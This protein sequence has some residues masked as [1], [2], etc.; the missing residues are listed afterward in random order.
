MSAINSSTLFHFT[1]KNANFKRIVQKGLRFSYSFETFSKEL[2]LNELLPASITFPKDIKIGD[3]SKEY[4]VAIPMVCFC[5]IPLLRVNE[6]KQK[7]GNYAI[8]VDKDFLLRTPEHAD[9]LRS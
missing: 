9:P 6:H 4:G 1:K 8:G 3:D 7:Y 5:D 2:I